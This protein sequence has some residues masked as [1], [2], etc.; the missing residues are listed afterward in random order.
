[1]GLECSHG[2]FLGSYSSFFRF[3][4]AICRAIDLNEDSWAYSEDWSFPPG[5]SPESHPGL[6]ELLNHPD[7]KGAISP[8]LCG[9]IAEELTDFVL[10]K[11]EESMDGKDLFDGGY[12][13]VC[14]KFICGCQL[15]ASRNE[16]MIF[17]QPEK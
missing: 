12:A 16:H 13:E 11:L 14:R 9:A 15:A 6:W 4:C 5:Y 7:H 17:D 1:M 10:A 2:A 3:R 8:E